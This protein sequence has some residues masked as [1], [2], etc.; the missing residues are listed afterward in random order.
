MKYALLYESAD[1]VLVKA[2][3]HIA[4]HGARLAEF[5]RRGTLLMG[6]VFA[7]PQEGALVIFTTREAAEEFARSDPFVVN[8]VVRAW[9]IYEWNETQFGA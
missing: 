6:G 3:P 2:R 1:D 5:R 4:A 9:R 8:G 7:N